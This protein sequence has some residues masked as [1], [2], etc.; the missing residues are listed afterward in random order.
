MEQKKNLS[1]QKKQQERSTKPE[2]ELTLQTV[3]MPA[4]SN[5]YGDIFGGWLLSQMDLAG[6]V[7]AHQY[8]RHR[9]TTVAIEKM[10]FVKPVFV[11]DLVCCYARPIKTGRSSIT[12]QVDVWVVRLRIKER[13]QV[14][15]GIFIYVALDDNRKPKTIEW[16]L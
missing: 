15:A 3:A 5:A 13:V 7:L 2:G 6:S 10:T 16:Q 9:I 11:G 12:I 1:E 8:A 4:D 14:A